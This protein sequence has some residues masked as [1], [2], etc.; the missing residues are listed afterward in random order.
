MSSSSWRV[1][2]ASEL[3]EQSRFL[4]LHRISCL[5]SNYRLLCF[6]L[7]IFVKVSP[8]GHSLHMRMAENTLDGSRFLSHF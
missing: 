2:I 7:G 3:P 5:V 8:P 1:V 4:Q 6:A